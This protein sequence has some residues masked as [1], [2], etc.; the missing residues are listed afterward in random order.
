MFLSKLSTIKIRFFFRPV[1][2]S[3]LRKIYPETCEFV[4]RWYFNPIKFPDSWPF[5]SINLGQQMSKRKQLSANYNNNLLFFLW[6]FVEIFYFTILNAVESFSFFIDL[7]KITDKHAPVFRSQL[8]YYRLVY[9]AGC[10]FKKKII[11][12]Q[13]TKNHEVFDLILPWTL[14]RLPVQEWNF[15]IKKNPRKILKLVAKVPS[16]S[17]QPFWRLCE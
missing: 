14:Y 6:F 1:T 8:V 11:F 10:I 12:P 15:G 13:S 7:L 17:V 3:D 4:A 9:F 2:F 16:Q 5:R